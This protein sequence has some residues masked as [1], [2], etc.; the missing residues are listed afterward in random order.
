M[1]TVRSCSIKQYGAS[2]VDAGVLLF[3]AN[4]VA[5]DVIAG[6]EQD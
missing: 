6:L 4:R 2:V 3:E 5:Y 1:P